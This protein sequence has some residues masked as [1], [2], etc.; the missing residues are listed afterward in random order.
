MTWEPRKL[1]VEAVEVAQ[2]PIMEKVEAWACAVGWGA[3]LGKG[4]GVRRRACL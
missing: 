3:F 1:G 2:G 4:G